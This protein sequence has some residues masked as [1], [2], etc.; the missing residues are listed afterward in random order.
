M[1]T[2]VDSNSASGGK[3]GTIS[4]SLSGAPTSGSVLVC[5][6]VTQT[7]TNDSIN[8]S[9]TDSGVGDVAIGGSNCRVWYK[10]ATGTESATFT[11]TLSGG[12]ASLIWAAEYSSAGDTFTGA[13]DRSSSGTSIA[14]GGSLGSASS[15]L[16]VMFVGQDSTTADYSSPSTGFSI[17]LKDNGGPAF[18]AMHDL[19]AGTSRTPSITTDDGTGV[20]EAVHLAFETAAT[21][22]GGAAIHAY[23]LMG[24]P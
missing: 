22:P 15:T 12:A 23:R 2:L 19:T 3:G 13:Q 1:A 16:H 20:W 7:Q 4:V 24:G 8:N 11:V 5:G 14:M 6:V 17:D 9:M 21:T 10:I 18:V